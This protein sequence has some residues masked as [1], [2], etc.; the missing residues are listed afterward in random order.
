MNRV[1]RALAPVG[2]L[3]PAALLAACAIIPPPTPDMAATGPAPADGPRSTTV[4]FAFD[5]NRVF[6]PITLI[7]PDGGEIRTLAFLNQGSPAPVLSNTLYRQLGMGPG[8][9]LKMRLGDMTIEAAPETVQTEVIAG[10]I[11]LIIGPRALRRR[12][13]PTA[14]QQ[15]AASVYTSK[16]P[17]GALAGLDPP[18]DIGMVFPAGLLQRYRVTLDYDAKTLTLAPS[19]GAAPQGVAVP[20]AVNPTTGYAT[21]LMAFAG[22]P[23]AMAIDAGGSYSALRMDEADALAR[24]HPDWLRSSGPIGEAQFTLGSA[25]VGEPVIQVPEVELGALTLSPFR[26]VGAGFRGALG[27]VANPVFWNL[28]SSRQGQKSDGW[29][30]GNVL[31]SFRVTLD[32]P[33][34]MSWWLKEAPLDEGD[35]DQ[36]GLTLART[37]AGVTVTQVL[38][39]DGRTAAPGVKRGDRILAVD[40]RPLDKATRGEALTALHGKPGERRRLTL[41][42]KGKTLEVEAP[43]TGF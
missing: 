38:S 8:R 34:G 42:R 17:G 19:G 35:L 37:G 22:R 43:V 21:V 2:C 30:G 3:L 40:G 14:A 15:L 23:H 5:G 11:N 6:L 41:E 39:K 20:M 10:N 9:P 36:V 27:V 1:A 12:T 4:A 28:Y 32:Y 13:P 26:A 31:K 29:I 24:T 25:D 18:L 16:L 7:K 33:A